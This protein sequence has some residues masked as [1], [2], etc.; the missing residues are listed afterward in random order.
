MDFVTIFG[1]SFLSI[2]SILAIPFAIPD[3]NMHSGII[4][5]GEVIALLVGTTALIKFIKGFREG[6]INQVKDDNQR[7]IEEIT[8][9][10]DV[11]LH[12]VHKCLENLEKK[13]DLIHNDTKENIGEIKGQLVAFTNTIDLMKKDVATHIG[14][15]KAKT[16]SLDKSI[17]DLKDSNNNNK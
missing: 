11:K 15:S 9:M 6:T 16:E 12:S 17:E 1:L 7:T 13:F 4:V 14:W 3:I 2:L 10:A 8:K 5:L